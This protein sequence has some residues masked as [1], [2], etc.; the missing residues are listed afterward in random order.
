MA[1]ETH[2]KS[3]ILIG[4]KHSG[5][6]TQGRLLSDRLGLPFFDTDDVILEVTGKSPRQ[7]YTQ[8]GQEGFVKAE[9]RACQYLAQKL[10]DSTTGERQSAVI[11]TGGG[12][13][14]NE[15]AI[16]VLKQIGVFVLLNVDEATSWERI[17]REVRFEGGKIV[18]APAYIAQEHPTT[19]GEAKAVFHGFFC[20][21]EKLYRALADITV[22]I[23]PS[24]TKEETSRKIISSL[25]AQGVLC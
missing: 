15:R 21:R 12:I 8:Q 10:V 24:S 23:S 17:C 19:I 13:C 1:G 3:I 4:I 16:A 2:M 25:K 9:E 5:K 18:N 22:D 7:I 14:A 6:S 20:K 11:A